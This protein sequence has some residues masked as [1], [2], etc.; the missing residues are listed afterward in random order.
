MKQVLWKIRITKFCLSTF[1]YDASYDREG[2]LQNGV[3]KI[4]KNGTLPGLK[5]LG[6]I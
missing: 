6:K 1:L 5:V 4:G 2:N 3:L